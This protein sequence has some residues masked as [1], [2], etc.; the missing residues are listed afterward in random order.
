VPDHPALHV[1]GDVAV[2]HPCAGVV[3]A[4]T[5][6]ISIQFPGKATTLVQLDRNDVDAK[7]ALVMPVASRMR[8]PSVCM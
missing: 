4:A 2:H 7:R 8:N 5:N 6:T 3:L 1:V